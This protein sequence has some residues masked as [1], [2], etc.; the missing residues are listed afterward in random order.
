MSREI[1]IHGNYT[2]LKIEETEKG[3]YITA[4][5]DGEARLEISKETFE[6]VHKDYQFGVAEDE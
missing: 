2:T 6:M 5:G 3:Y 4:Y 1:R